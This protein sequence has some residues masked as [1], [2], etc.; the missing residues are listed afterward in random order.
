MEPD[1]IENKN[2]V[3]RML[4]F[5]RVG[6]LEDCPFISYTIALMTQSYAPLTENNEENSE[7]K[8]E[9]RRGLVWLRRSDKFLIE[10]LHAAFTLSQG[11]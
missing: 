3:G 6:V 4:A 1:F 2:I 9:S 10:V 8:G 7:V 11:L 5:P